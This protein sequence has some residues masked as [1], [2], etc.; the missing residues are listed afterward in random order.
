MQVDFLIVGAQKSGTS[1]LDKYMRTHSE[2]EMATRKEVHFFDTDELFN[3][4][5]VDYSKYHK[6]FPGD[7]TV[8]IRGE[9]TPIYMYWNDAP[10]RIWQYNPEIKL[11]VV[12]RNPIERAFSHWNMARYRGVEDMSFSDAIKA[13][14]LRCRVS[15]P[16][17]NRVFS[18]CDRGFYSFQL[19]R[20]WQFF[21]AEQ[22]LILKFENL[23]YD[24]KNTLSGIASF[25]NVGEFESSQYID[26]HSTDYVTGISLEDFNLLR[27]IFYYE[28][29]M[30]EELLGWDCEQWLNL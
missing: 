20:L 27:E 29:K 18:Y 5:K 2:I 10:K 26:T 22:V 15:L 9:S 1:A 3:G 16:N 21:P 19:R 14:S 11:I 6:S 17:Q 7:T 12:L 23:K 25:L 4:G 8:S 24:L 28:I 30:L 13:E